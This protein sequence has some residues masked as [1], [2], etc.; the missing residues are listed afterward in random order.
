MAAVPSLLRRQTGRHSSL[1]LPLLTQE[2]RAWIRGK[3]LWL[4]A[5]C[6]N[7]NSQIQQW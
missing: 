2:G 6:S 7:L 1:P 3:P 5:L 4:C